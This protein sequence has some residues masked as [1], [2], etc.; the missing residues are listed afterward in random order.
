M[1][2]KLALT[3]LAAALLLL[4]A[5]APAHDNSTDGSVEPVSP[6]ISATPSNPSTTPAVAVVTPDASDTPIAEPDTAV[7]RE[8]IDAMLPIMDSIVLATGIAGDTEYTPEDPEYFW[9][10]LYLMGNNWGRTNPLV[11]AGNEWEILEIVVPTQVMKEYAKAAFANCQSLPPIPDS[12]QDSIK[13][14]AEKSAYILAPSDRGGTHTQIDEI[15]VVDEISVNVTVGLYDGAGNPE[16][17]LGSVLFTLVKNTN[18]EDTNSSA[19]KYSVSG[20]IKMPPA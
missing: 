19:Y 13:L 8:D 4:C 17:I 5:C 10:V 15:T 2:K 1:I 18:A 11:E 6:D 9:Y 12:L 3:L 20:V 7:I 16:D 14:D